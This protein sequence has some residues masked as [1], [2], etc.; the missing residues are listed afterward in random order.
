[1]T[2]FLFLSSLANDFRRN[3]VKLDP[4]LVAQLDETRRLR[5]AI[6]YSVCYCRASIVHYAVGALAPALPRVIDA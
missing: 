1:M 6:G 5:A 2:F 3:R 4:E